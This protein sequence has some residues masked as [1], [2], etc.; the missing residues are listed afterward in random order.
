MSP[1]SPTFARS[2]SLSFCRSSVARRSP[3]VTSR[4]RRRSLNSL[5]N[6]SPLVL[7]GLAYTCGQ[8]SAV[9]NDSSPSRSLSRSTHVHARAPSGRDWPR[10]HVRPPLPNMAVCQ[11]PPLSPS[12]RR[13]ATRRAF[14]DSLASSLHF[15]AAETHPRGFEPPFTTRRRRL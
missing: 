13:R 12:S 5:G 1:S 15:G 7:A 3:D 14:L 9:L 4:R 2:P 8:N 11:S 10:R 6:F